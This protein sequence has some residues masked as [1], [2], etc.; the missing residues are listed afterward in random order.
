[1]YNHKSEYKVDKQSYYVALYQ[2]E[3]KSQISKNSEG[4]K[5]SSHLNLILVKNYNFI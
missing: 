1:M 5:Y 2:S 4:F 3:K